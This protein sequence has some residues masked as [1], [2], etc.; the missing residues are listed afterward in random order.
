[1][2]AVMATSIRKDHQTMYSPRIRAEHIPALYRLARSRR[3]PM[4]V[5]IDQTLGALLAQP[6]AQAAIARVA[7]PPKPTVM[8]TDAATPARKD[9]KALP[10]N[11]NQG[12]RQP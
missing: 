6:D 7:I 11:G 1:V 10:T 4:T 2:L 9:R 5:L 12:E 8:R 3:I